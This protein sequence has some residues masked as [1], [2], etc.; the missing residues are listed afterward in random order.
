MPMKWVAIDTHRPAL[1]LRRILKFIWAFVVFV[2]AAP[3]VGLFA[4]A[5]LL[6]ILDGGNMGTGKAIAAAIFGTVLLAPYMIPASYMVGGVAAFAAGLVIVFV[7]PYIPAHGHRILFAA[8]I[9][10]PAAA[11]LRIPIG[12]GEDSRTE[13][14]AYAVAGG[15]A[16]A[17][18][19]WRMKGLVLRGLA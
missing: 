18:S 8:M 11:L 10:T 9:G 13:I 16:A 2:V 17:V 19:V 4:W 7:S 14:A 15:I 12:Y 6:A 1:M 3:P 5:I